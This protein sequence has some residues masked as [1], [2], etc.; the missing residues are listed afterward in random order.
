MSQLMS[1]PSLVSC[2]IGNLLVMSSSGTFQ[3]YSCTV[4]MMLCHSKCTADAQ[5]LFTEIILY[6][7]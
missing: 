5:M 7:F 6:L 1:E 3:P 4:I 2:K